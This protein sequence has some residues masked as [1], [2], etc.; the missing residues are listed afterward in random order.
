MK[1]APNRT[2]VTGRLQKFQPAAD[3]YGGD[4]VIEVATNESPVPSAD[5]IKPQAGK[6]LRAFY[7]EPSE[8]EISSLMGHLVRVDL[9]YLGGPSGGRAVV[10]SLKAASP[11]G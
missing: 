9:T 11:G 4:L 7:P 1:T 6:L 8:R 5:F 3:G 2:V 10:R